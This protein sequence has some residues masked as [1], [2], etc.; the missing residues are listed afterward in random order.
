[1]TSLRG[2]AP[3]GVL[4]ALA[5]LAACG[6]ACAGDLKEYQTRYYVITTDHDTETVREAAARLTAMAEEYHRRT[7]DFSG[8]IRTRLPFYLFST[9][10]GFRET[11]GRG[12]GLYTG[13]ALLAHLP[14]GGRQDVWHVVQHEGFH[15]FVDKV[16]RGHIPI[17]VNEGLA[18]YFGDGFVTG[19]IPRARL[20]RIRSAIRNDRFKP[21]LD[22][23]LLGN[24]EWRAELDM[25]NYDQAWSMVH[26]LVHAED[27]RYRDVFSA[28]IRDISG[29][30]VTSQ[31]F[32]DRFGRDLD[33]FRLAY[34]KWWLSLPDDPTRDRYTQAVCET[35]TSFLA[36]AHSQGR[37]F[38]TA[39]EFFT[40]S[41]AGQPPCPAKQWLPP[42]L[43]EEALVK[44]PRLGRWSI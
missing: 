41:R 37:T 13:K 19:V 10:T 26:F 39:E 18:E 25:R 8:K 43:L 16:I 35:L 11:G 38:E 15:Q 27:G 23:L 9:M 17:W 5:V 4:A 1:M 40:A 2:P 6:T 24:N 44:S 28:F 31:A 3:L 7:K 30:R 22:F 12:A 20:R 33:A 14:K 36:R 42:T 21:V 32:R 29:G 34:D